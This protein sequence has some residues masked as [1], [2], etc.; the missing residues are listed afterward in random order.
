VICTPTVPSGVATETGANANIAPS[1]VD[2]SAWYVVWSSAM[3]GAEWTSQSS[4]FKDSGSR[5][6]PWTAR[7]AQQEDVAIERREAIQRLGQRRGQLL[8]RGGRPLIEFDGQAA[9]PIVADV[10]QRQ[11]AGDAEDPRAAGARFGRRQ[12]TARDAEEDLLRQLAGVSLADDA[13]Q[14]AEDPVAVRG[15]K[16]VSVRQH[17]LYPLRTP[18]EAEALSLTAQSP[19]EPPRAGASGSAH[20]PRSP[21]DGRGPYR[22]PALSRAPSARRGEGPRLHRRCRGR[23][24]D[25]GRT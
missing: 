24:R 15:E 9:P 6:S 10:V 13:A 4:T 22:R 23:R 3:P 17:S 25:C 21:G 5:F 16:D 2:V 12:R 8:R 11:V 7:L 19:S 20:R 18:D 14:V 1:R